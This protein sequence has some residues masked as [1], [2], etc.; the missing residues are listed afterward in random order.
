MIL[1]GRSIIKINF[2]MI[3]QAGRVVLSIEDA[4]VSPA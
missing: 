4:K 1:N 3:G 2:S